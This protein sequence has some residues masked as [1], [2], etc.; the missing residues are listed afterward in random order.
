MKA[1]IGSFY[2]GMGRFL[3]PVFLF[4]LS[5]L[6]QTGCDNSDSI[7]LKVDES[8]STQA[9]TRD[10][11]QPALPKVFVTLPQSF[12]GAIRVEAKEAIPLEPEGKPD[13]AVPRHVILAIEGEYADLVRDSRFTPGIA[14]Y[15]VER[16]RDQLSTQPD[17]VA[18]F[19]EGLKALKSLLNDKPDL[20]RHGR[21]E[22]VRYVENTQVIRAHAKYLSFNGVDVLLNVTQFQPDAGYINNRELTYVVQGLTTDGKYYLFG[23]FPVAAAFLPEDSDISVFEGYKIPML[24]PTEAEA[25]EHS[26]YLKR[27]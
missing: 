3:L 7:D 1:N 23:T 27:V 16:F 5:M 22:I 8:F 9:T 11:D 15:E 18:D 21:I 17:V 2:M 4:A 26:R 19:N 24:S 14:V 6:S 20:N 25:E 12:N 13:S 10:G